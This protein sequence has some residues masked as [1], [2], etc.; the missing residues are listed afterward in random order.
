MPHYDIVQKDVEAHLRQ[1]PADQRMNPQVRKAAYQ[2]AVGQNV[3]KIMAAQKE[4]ILRSAAADLTMAPS[5]QSG[6]NTGAQYGA[7]IPDPKKV[8]GSDALTALRSKGVSVDQ[9]Y[10]RRG[11]DGWEDY[12][13]KV[14]KDYF[15]EEN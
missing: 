3:D 5:G 4:E 12:W 8:L 1:L 2:L 10:Q 15:G 6:R 13:N 14:G 11:Y 7:D 9:E